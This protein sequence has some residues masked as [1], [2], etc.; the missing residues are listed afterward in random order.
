MFAKKKFAKKK[1]WK[2]IMPK[3]HIFAGKY[4]IPPKT[5]SHQGPDKVKVRW[6]QSNY[7]LDLNCNLMGFDTIEINLV[8]FF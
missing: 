3:K 4:K 7:N 5:R 2:K 6:R 8:F 1:F